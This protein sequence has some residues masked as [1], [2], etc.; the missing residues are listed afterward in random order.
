METRA[1]PHPPRLWGCL[2]PLWLV[3]LLGL[4]RS[5][6]AEEVVLLDSKASQAELGWTALPS[7]G[8]EEISGVDEHDRPIR[9]YQVCNV[10]EPSQDNWLQ[11][12]WI[13]RGRGQRIFVELQFTLRDCSSIPGAAGTCKE[14]FNVYYVETEADL[15]RGRPRLGGSRPRKIDTIAAD[16]SFTQGDLGE[17][18]M[19]LNTEVREIGPLSRRG[20]HLAFQDVGAC[21]ALVSVRVYYKQCRA[22]VRGLAAFPATAAESAFST[23]VEVTGTCVAHSEGE[24]GS[25][26][27]MHCGADGEWLVPVGR[28][29]CSAG[30]QERGDICEA[31]PPGFYK[32]SPRRPLCSPCPEHSRAPEKASTYCV[33]QDSYARS[34][35]D[36][37]SASCTRP[38]SAPRD[39]Q[40]SLSRSPLALRLRWLPPA[41]S[42]GRSD[43][44]Y[45]LLCL[46]CGRDGPAG[47]CEPCGPRVAFV[48]RQAGLRER[49]A[50]LL[51]LRPGARY[52][53]RVAALNGVS[54]PAAAAGAT[55]AQ[56]TVSTGPGAPWEEDE[57]RRDRVEPQSVS[58]SWRE[59]IPA[60]GPGANNTEYEIR[61]Y[62]KGQSEQAYSTV[63]TGAPAVTVT[64]LKPATRYVFQIRAA[65]PGPSW[66]AQSFNPSIEVQTPGEVASEPRDQS[67]A[68]V[69]TVV[70]ISA[71]LVLGSVMSV[72]AIWRR[73]C[74]YGKGGADAH[75]EEEL[76]FHFKVPTRRTFLDPQ[77]CGDPLQAVHLFAK[78]L[79]AK[80][81]TLERSLGT[82]R[83]GELCCGCLQLPGR[84][85]LPVAVHMLREGCPDSQRLSFLAEALTLGQF[86]HSHIVRLE[87][88][89]TRGSPLMIVTEYMSHGALDDF[90]RQ[91]EGQ[92]AAGQLLGF[93]PGL[94]SAMKYLSEMGYVHRGLAARRVLVSPGLV[95]KISGFGRGPRDRAEAVY[96]TMSGRSPA[97]W[98]A[99]ET[100]QFGHF[101]SASDVW[102]FGVV[103]WEVMAFGERPYWDMSGQDV[104]KAVEDGFRLPPPR[105]CP[106]AL[107]RLMLDCW[108]KDPGERPRFSQIHSLLSRMGQDPEPPKSAVVPCPRP[109]TPLADRAFSTF[110]SFCSVG[111]WLEALD[112]C[113]YKDSFAAAGYGT[114]EAVA[115]MTAQDLTSLGI[116]SAEH[117]EALLSGIG[118]LRARVL[119]LQ[120]QGVQV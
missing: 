44:T 98:A 78:E 71:L 64:N 77:S 85:A 105:N 76:Y 70:T 106:S 19:K 49:A 9:T 15:G 26:P 102:S 5:G 35:T 82:G 36:P 43:V 90:L 63:K 38:P 17:R 91:H 13:S 61:Y 39:L 118:A 107:H 55:Y 93:L 73:P 53:V 67:P 4:W 48:P 103:M 79:D 22:T 58:L 66:E 28:C 2:T 50:T 40:Y 94:A 65:S 21:V 14:T 72:L 57:I 120:G 95:C 33:C 60:G 110:P 16:E 6:T 81:V 99:P 1:A 112:L 96:T 83:F 56:V 18:K 29:S 8:W 31:C 74:N 12:G 119:Q 104:I 113:R 68:V 115:E 23:L 24:P 101:S 41:D 3:L 54:G 114:L 42:G 51:H 69:V 88:V 37:P 117:R 52:T 84:Q 45:S 86:D 75:D 10:L 87:G 92:L 97:L 32:V 27:R 20:F 25:P 62:E 46:R 11:T 47:A 116:S 30:F 89:V 111:A 59:P 34:P 7:N 109:P 108:Q 100:L 80:S